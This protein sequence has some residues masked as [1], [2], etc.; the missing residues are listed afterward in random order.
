VYLILQKKYNLIFAKL[1]PNLS[2]FQPVAKMNKQFFL[3]L[4]VIIVLMVSCN[5]EPLPPMSI[6]LY[7]TSASSI[8]SDAAI[9]GGTIASSGGLNVAQKGICW[10]TSSNPTVSNSKTQD[11]TG[12]GSFSS[13]I[14]GLTPS[15]N[16]YVRAYA[17]TPSGTYYGNQITFAT[18]ASLA[19]ITTNSIT[20]ISQ[21]SAISGGVITA[22]GGAAITQRGV[23]W[24]TTTN[25][26]IMNSKTINGS[27]NGSFNSSITGLSSNTIYYVRAYAT[28]S[29]GTNYGN[30]IS[31][32]TSSS[33][34]T[35]STASITSIG[36]ST[37]ISGGNITSS[38]TNVTQRGVCWSTSSLP[39]ISNN[40]TIDGIGVGTF[41]SNITGLTPNTIYFV[42]AYATNSGGTAY[43]NELSFT[44]ATLPTL[45]TSSANSISQ[46]TAI[47]GGNITSSGGT[48]I[49][50]RGVCWNTTI[51]P[52][53]ANSK[54]ND[55]TG[56]G[57]YTSS[58]SGLN[59][60]TTYYIRAYAT[61]SAGTSYGNLLGF[62]TT[63]ATL[64]ILSTNSATSIT[65]TTALSG[66]NITSDGGAG[67]TQRGVCWSMTT[68]PTIINSKTNDGT[69]V[70]AFSSNISGLNPNTTYYVR[71]YATN[72]VGTSYGSQ[73]ILTTIAN[74]PTLTTS[75]VTTITQT[76]SNCGGNISSNGGASVTQ[77]GVCWNTSPTPTILNNKTNDGTGSGSFT[78]AMTG[79]TP[80]TTYY[81][82][83]YAT[84]SAGTGYGNEI[85]FTT[86]ALGVPILS[87]P[88]NGSAISG[89]NANR[90][91]SWSVVTGATSYEI[92]I[93]KTSTFTGTTTT[94]L[95]C[96][97][98]SYPSTTGI[99]TAT[100]S[101]TNFCINPGLASNNGTWYWRVRAKNGSV[102]GSWS[103][104]FSY[105]YTF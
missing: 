93:S 13:N 45:T 26:T 92:N 32:T 86:L 94:I 5:K 91:F 27:G 95:S 82:R 58:I 44:T 79:L 34:A 78:S 57:A 38:S 12:T 72:S 102:V 40:I 60:N 50:Q 1:T 80:S 76:T 2:K 55:G 90:T 39:T 21:T 69:G 8:S 67:I 98:S 83:A 10:S 23:C 43:G 73:I 51:N 18:I 85:N 105:T 29:V 25:P 81:T 47:A 36:S 20:S 100:S 14:N 99:K 54:T 16:Y 33:L 64:P 41:T 48:S 6:V 68:N 63:A 97:N 101:T 62:T 7:T 59:A 77:R 28:N 17:T 84:N 4:I 22:N 88:S 37:A 70:G 42:R 53:I 31:F 71:A 52:T 30:E 46:T 49:I 74:L 19:T 3:S 9:S 56:T 65:Q 104:V 66:G 103:S 15:T 24:S 87:L 61:N 11:G 75:T 89:G 35:I 96:G